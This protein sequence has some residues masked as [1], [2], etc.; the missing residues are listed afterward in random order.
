MKSNI[1]KTKIINTDIKFC[2]TKNTN[3][4]TILDTSLS[5]EKLTN[6]FNKNGLNEFNF[7]SEKYN[8]ISPSPINSLMKYENYINLFDI[9]VPCKDINN[10]QKECEYL[11]TSR[12]IR[13]DIEIFLHNL[14]IIQII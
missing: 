3:D 14:I 9:K 4:I 8:I 12:Y 6:S 2:Y 7:N 1:K 13:I 11:N 10:I 5:S